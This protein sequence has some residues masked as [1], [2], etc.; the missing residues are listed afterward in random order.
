MFELG[1]TEYGIDK[2]F[3]GSAKCKLEEQFPLIIFTFVDCCRASS[4]IATEAGESEGRTP[5]R[6]AKTMK[7]G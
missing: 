7:K 1:C 5:S 3:R 2:T 4:L 6:D